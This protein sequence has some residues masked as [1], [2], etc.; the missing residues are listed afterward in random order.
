MGA[1]HPCLELQDNVAYIANDVS[2]LRGKER[3]RRVW[4]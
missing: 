3:E 1:R 2:L 4:S